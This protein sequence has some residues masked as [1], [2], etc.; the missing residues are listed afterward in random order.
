M[1]DGFDVVVA[2]SESQILTP[3]VDG[4]TFLFFVTDTPE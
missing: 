2:V 3:G 4:K 1:T